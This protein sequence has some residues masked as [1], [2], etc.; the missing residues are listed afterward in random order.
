MDCDD[1]LAPYCVPSDDLC[2]DG[3]TGDPCQNNGD[4]IANCMMGTCT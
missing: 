2:H 1:V 4:C 3:S